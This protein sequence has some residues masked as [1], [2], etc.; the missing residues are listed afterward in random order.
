MAEIIKIDGATV[1]VGKDDG[2]VISVPIACLA[3]SN[4]KVGDEVKL[5]K[6]GDNFIVRLAKKSHSDSPEGGKTLNK[7]IFVWVCSFALGIFGVDRFIRGK[8][9]SGVCKLL[10]WGFTFGIW[11][12]VDWITALSKA[13]GS[14]FGDVEEISFDSKGDYTR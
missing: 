6:D 13:Y 1:K 3:F 11:P 2:K 9:G 5:Y 12:L 8:I 10:F 14:A 7:H 4:P